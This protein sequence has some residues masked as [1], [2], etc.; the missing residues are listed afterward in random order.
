M[1]H[2]Q[3]QLMGLRDIPDSP[4]AL[5]IY[6]R[7]ACSSVPKAFEGYRKENKWNIGG[8]YE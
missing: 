4:H 5:C 1:F 2:F 6:K 3:E 8:L 7:D